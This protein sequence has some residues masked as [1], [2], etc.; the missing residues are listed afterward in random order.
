[1][2]RC[3]VHANC[4]GDP[5]R[6]LLL[7]SPAFR[8]CYTL[9]KYTNFLKEQ[10]PGADIDQAD[11]FLYQHVDA[12]WGD[13]ASDAILARL[14]PGCR[15]LCLPNLY[16]LPYWPLLIRDPDFDFSDRF[17]DKLIAMGLSKAEILHVYLRPNLAEKYDLDALAAPSLDKERRKE[18]RTPIRLLD[19]ILARFRRERLFLTVNHP[20]K[21]LCVEIADA[22]LD[23][24]DLPPLAPE[25]IADYPEP[26]GDF[27]QPI[28]PG[29]IR[30]HGLAWLTPE[31]AFH[32]HGKPMTFA[33]YTG[34]YIDAKLQDIKSF[35]AYLHLV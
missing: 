33:D 29:V 18:A 24:L 23:F 16:F 17:L 3:L 35:A 10:V 14:K 31:T 4:Q 34:H 32:V 6:D 13:L 11:V 22:V 8:E 2:Q 7:R 19:S 21:A 28:H 5:L 27:E 30:H 15:V 20:S 12:G 9:K 25:D 26:F 1:M